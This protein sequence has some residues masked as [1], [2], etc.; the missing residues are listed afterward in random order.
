ML[1]FFNPEFHVPSNP[2]FYNVVTG[3]PVGDGMSQRHHREDHHRSCPTSE[4]VAVVSTSTASVGTVGVQENVV[5]SSTSHQL[6][7]DTDSGVADTASE[8]G[9]CRTSA[10]RTSEERRVNRRS[11][12][13]AAASAVPASTSSVDLQTL[14]DPSHY[15]ELSVIG[16]GKFQSPQIFG[17][18]RSWDKLSPLENTFPR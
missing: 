1:L 15:E 7:S 4:A 5:E 18:K 11:A 3:R 6:L 9:G 12:A 2:D 8:D 13:A 17:V 10:S 16:N 14:R